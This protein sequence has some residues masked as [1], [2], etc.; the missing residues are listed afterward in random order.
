MSVGHLKGI[1]RTKEELLLIMGEADTSKIL[2]KPK[3]LVTSYDVPYGGGTS[4]AG[5][6]I[7]I[8]QQLYK[9]VMW[10]PKVPRHLWV[11]VPGMTGKQIIGV[12]TKHE[13]TEISVELGDNASDTYQ[14]SHGF[15][16]AN[17]EDDVEAILGKGRA[18]WYEKKIAPALLRCLHRSINKIRAASFNPPACLWCGPILDEPDAKDLVLIRGLKACNVLDAFKQSKSDDDIQYGMGGRKCEDCKMMQY[19]NREL[20]PCELVCGRVRWN[21]QCEKFV[22]R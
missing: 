21:R 13:D 1:A 16:T 15:G 19:P 11:I 22:A 17:E 3:R 10:S 6:E 20:S 4:V 18:G 12:W 5:D 14:S 9:E 7:Y 8:D 2:A